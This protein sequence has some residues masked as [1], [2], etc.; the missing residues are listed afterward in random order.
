MDR[1]SEVKCLPKPTPGEGAFGR[2]ISRPPSTITTGD[3][4]FLVVLQILFLP[5]KGNL[6]SGVFHGTGYTGNNKIK[7]MQIFQGT[8]ILAITASPNPDEP[9]RVAPSMSL[10]RS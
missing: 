10:S 7:T 5:N 9:T 2:R 8:R 6:E 4:E 1:L 3:L